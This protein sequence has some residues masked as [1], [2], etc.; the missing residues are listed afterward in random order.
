MTRAL[1]DL[2]PVAETEM[3]AE[4]PLLVPQML[5][6]LLELLDL[7]CYCC[8]VTLG[9]RLPELG[10]PFGRALDLGLDLR[11]CLHAL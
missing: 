6:S 4:H 7:S 11:E 3:G 10:A 5:D 8:V 2:F 1:D 9:K